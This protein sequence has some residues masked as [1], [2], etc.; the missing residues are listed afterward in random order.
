MSY[1]A[2]KADL[3]EFLD[4][5]FFGLI[6]LL[7]FALNETKGDILPNRQAV[8]KRRP[9]KQHTKVREY[10]ISFGAPHAGN[11]FASDTD[12]TFFRV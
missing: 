7:G 11:I 2:A 9:L 5:N 4:G 6:L 3:G 1:I 8:K 12:G 10:R